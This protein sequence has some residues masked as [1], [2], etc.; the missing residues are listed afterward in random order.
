MEAQDYVS[1]IVRLEK[2]ASR[3]GYR[4]LGNKIPK[5]ATRGPVLLTGSSLYRPSGRAI[6]A[7]NARPGPFGGI[8]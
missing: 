8:A 2:G 6:P 3:N 5:N 7:L 4:K 1:K